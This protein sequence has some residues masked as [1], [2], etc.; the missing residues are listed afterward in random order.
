MKIA[1]FEPTPPKHANGKRKQKSTDTRLMYGELLEDVPSDWQ[2]N[3]IVVPYPEGKRSLVS[4]G[5][6]KTVAYNK[7]GNVLKRF[8]STLPN[9]SKV[10]G[11]QH[12]RD[13]CLLDCVYDSVH[14]TYYVLD[15]LSWKD[16]A[17]GDCETNFRQFWLETR[18]VVD[19]MDPSTSTNSFYKFKHLR[20]IPAE[21][22]KQMLQH[23]SEY[24]QARG[25]NF[26][27]DGL[28]F[29]HRELLYTEGETPLLSLFGRHLSFA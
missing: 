11:K 8:E 26:N 2:E 15:I 19:E 10:Y 27:I 3:W 9:G 22:V 16:Y 5:N 21:D 7:F 18:L 20:P 14:W 4:S 1:C 23:P 28:M 24:L 6:G 12:H 29:Y 13:Y 25:D 17:V